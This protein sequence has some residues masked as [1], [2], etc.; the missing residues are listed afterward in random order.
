MWVVVVSGRKL[1]SSW[2]PGAQTSTEYN[3]RSGSH[4]QSTWFQVNIDPLRGWQL[5]WPRSV[6][7][8]QPSA[9]FFRHDI[10]HDQKTQNSHLKLTLHCDGFTPFAPSVSSLNRIIQ[11]PWYWID[12]PGTRNL[13]NHVLVKSEDALY[14]RCQQFKVNQCG[15]KHLPTY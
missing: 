4:L 3:C 5:N 9:P 15:I 13:Q 12:K 8:L 7:D 10:S 1:V 14:P 2:H 6:V 11:F